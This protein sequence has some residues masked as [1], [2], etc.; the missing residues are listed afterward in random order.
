MS[1]VAPRALLGNYNVFPEFVFSARSEDI[2]NALEAAYEDGFDVANMSLGGAAQGVQDLVSVAVNN[3]D[4]ANLVVA[5]ASGNVGPGFSTVSSPGSAARALTAGASSVGHGIIHLVTVGGQSFHAVKGELGPGPVTAPLRVLID[6]ASPFNGLSLACSPFAAGSLTGTIALISRGVCDFTDKLRNVQAA[7]GVGALVVNREPGALIMGGNGTPNQPTIPAFM[8]LQSDAAAL[9][10][11]DGVSTTL[12]QFGTYEAVA[13]NDDVIAD[14]TSWGPTDVDFR[15]KPDVMAPGVH[16][17]SS[18]PR[19]N[20]GGAPCFAFISGTSQATPHLAGSAAVVRQQHPQWSAAAV[21]SAIV[22][23]ADRNVVKALDNVTII[24][25]G[26]LVG[27]G[28]EN[29]LAAVQARVA[30]DPVSLSF[31]AVPAGSGQSMQSSVQLTNI[32][33]GPQTYT[34][35][36]VEA[37]G[38]GVTFSLPAAFLTLA[39]GASGSVTVSMAALKGASVGS[40][41]AVLQV[42]T[43]GQVVAQAMLYTQVK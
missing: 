3:M 6:V 26:T 43:G 21:R 28:R 31:G 12:P 39:P 41:Q 32:S 25:D 34:L 24:N 23:T 14:F 37:S 2:L 20:C 10:A 1:G 35:Q 18:I 36:V 17:V 16:I 22:N 33:A 15:V 38:S 5:V 30:L 8:A 11:A 7:G 42:S 4:R 27:T 19:S 9:K 13:A 40:K 29:L